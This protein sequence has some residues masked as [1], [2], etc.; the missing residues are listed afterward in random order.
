MGRR[1]RLLTRSAP[2]GGLYRAPASD[3]LDLAIG[4][5]ASRP[6][7]LW[8]RLFRA[9]MPH[10]Q[11]WIT[12]PRSPRSTRPPGM[13]AAE[14]SES[15]SG[16]AGRQLGDLRRDTTEGGWLNLDDR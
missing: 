6:E 4:E 16:V 15:R 12:C 11:S 1:D 8:E 2:E 7:A 14:R 13:S 5:D 9:T 3:L 10:G